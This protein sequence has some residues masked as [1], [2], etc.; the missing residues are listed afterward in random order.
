MSGFSRQRTPKRAF[1]NAW[2]LDAGVEARPDDRFRA[3]SKDEATALQ[4]T[5]IRRQPS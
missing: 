4:N 3:V 2:L 1:V 5:P